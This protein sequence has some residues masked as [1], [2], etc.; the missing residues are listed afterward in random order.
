MF[1]LADRGAPHL[2]R[3][4]IG[5]AEIPFAPGS[6]QTSNSFGC[7]RFRQPL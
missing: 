3:L 1:R 2:A 5:L 7:P 4:K 6:E